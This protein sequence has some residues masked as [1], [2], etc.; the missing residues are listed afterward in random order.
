MGDPREPTDPAILQALRDGVRER[1]GYP[2]AV[3]PPRAPRGDRALGRPALRRRP[4]SRLPRDPDARIEGGDLLVRPGRARPRRRSGHGRRDRAGVSRPRAWRGVRRGARR[5]APAARGARLPPDARR[6]PDG[7]VGPHRAA[8]AQHAEQ[9]DGSSRTTRAARRCCRA[10]T[11]AWLRP[12]VRR[13]IQRALVRRATA[14]R[15]PARGLDE[16]RRVQHALEAIVDDRLPQRVRRRRP[17]ADRRPPPLP[18]E[19]RHGAAGVRPAGL[20]R[21]LG[22][23]GAR[24]PRP[25]ELCAEADDPARRPRARGPSRRRRPGDDV[26]LDRGARRRDLGSACGA[27]S[28]AAACS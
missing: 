14:L 24:P 1:M 13:G 19:H 15:A 20:G 7:R 4:R 23:R 12:R 2:A 25:R 9:P 26:P 3:G 22:R 27:A 10:S 17:G 5:R 28:R 16:R 11:R 21:R 18:A 6:G 8:L